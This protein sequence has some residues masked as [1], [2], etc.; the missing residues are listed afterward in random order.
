MFG[1]RFTSCAP[2]AMDCGDDS[3]GQATA[4]RC[5]A[6]HELVCLAPSKQD[7]DPNRTHAC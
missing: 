3:A 6:G 1:V 2:M 7:P 5:S 4:A